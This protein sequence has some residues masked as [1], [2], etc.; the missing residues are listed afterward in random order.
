MADALRH[1]GL[2]VTVFDIGTTVLQTVDPE[3]GRLVQA[4]LERHDVDGPASAR[5]S[6]PSSSAGR[7]ARGARPRR[8]ARTSGHGPRRHGRSPVG[9][10]GRRRR[11]RD[12][13]R[14]VRSGSIARWSRTSPDVYAAGDCVETHHR[15]VEAPTYLPLGTTAHKQGRVAGENAVGGRARLRG[16]PRN[17]GRQGVRPGHRTDRIPR[18]GAHAATASTLAPSKRRPGT[19]RR[20]IRAPRSSAFASPAIV[21][22]AAC[23]ARR[24]SASYGAEVS[25]RLDVFATAIFHGMQRRRAWSNWISATRRPSAAR[26]TRFKRAAWSGRR[27]ALGR[28]THED[29]SLC[30]HPQR[31]PVADGGRLVQRPGRSR[32][33]EPRYPPARSRGHASTPRS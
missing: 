21:A 9:R 16:Q 26:G 18:R 8:D 2:E 14:A 13:A 19:T 24:S 4:E 11:A 28:K 10:A 30:V 1:R 7:R 25:K 27:T 5:P 32:Q 33:G 22:P 23:S 6:K 12:S 29:R 15:L 31:R 20:T 17:A 3:L